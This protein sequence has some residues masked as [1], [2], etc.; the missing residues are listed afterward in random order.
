MKNQPISI[1]TAQKI[2]AKIF[3][4]LCK[5]EEKGEV[6]YSY[7]LWVRLKPQIKKD[8][9]EHSAAVLYFSGLNYLNSKG[10]VY[11]MMKRPLEI[12]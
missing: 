2:A 9:P 3:S 8:Y 5:A 10:I 12:L 6:I 1:H 4:A 11:N 7:D